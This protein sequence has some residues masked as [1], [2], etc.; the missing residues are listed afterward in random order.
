MFKS[1]LFNRATL[2]PNA[3]VASKG[4]AQLRS[5]GRWP[6]AAHDSRSTSRACPECA[7]RA[8]TTQGVASA[9]GVV[10]SLVLH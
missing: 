2:E 5:P 6:L 3:T 9:R 7:R 8:I 4:E 10:S 1:A